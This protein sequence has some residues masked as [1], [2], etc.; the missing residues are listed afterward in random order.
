MLVNINESLMLVI[1]LCIITHLYSLNFSKNYP[2]V[3]KTSN[4]IIRETQIKN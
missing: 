2:D 3:K 1:H 4:I